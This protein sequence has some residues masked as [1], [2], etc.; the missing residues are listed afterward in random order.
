MGVLVLCDLPEKVKAGLQ[1]RAAQH[2]RS[3]E[4]EVHEVLQQAAAEVLGETA[5]FVEPDDAWIK[6]VEMYPVEAEAWEVFDQS[7]VQSRSSW[8]DKP[9]DLDQ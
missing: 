2:G 1:R 7:L 4:A 9:L 3:L 5:N 8:R 6:R